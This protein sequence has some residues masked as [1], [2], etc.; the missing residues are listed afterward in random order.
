[1]ARDRF[2]KS[3]ANLVEKNLPEVA[4][5]GTA[6]LVSV[7]SEL[8]LALRQADLNQMQYDLGAAIC[9]ALLLE[10]RQQDVDGL[11]AQIALEAD[12]EPDALA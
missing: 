10:A 2:V 7:A 5:F 6:E 9:S 4:A 1:M 8:L 12:D 3:F 11:A